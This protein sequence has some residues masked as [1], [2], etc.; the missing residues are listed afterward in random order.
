[1]STDSKIEWCD[2]SFAPWFGCKKVDRECRLCYAE[3]WTVRRFKKAGWGNVPRVRSAA[4]TWRQ[5]LAWQRKAAKEGLR[6]RVFCSHESDVFDNQAR[7]EWRADIWELIRKCPDLDWL[8]LTKRPQNIRKML[9][10]DWGEGW[11]NVW[12]GTTAGHQTAWNRVKALRAI[13]AVLRF[14]S[15]E[16]LL[17]RVD[18][19]LDGISWVICGAETDPQKK[20][21]E[22]F[23]EPDWARDLL[24]QCR[25]AGVA[26][27]MKQMSG[28]APIPDD[29]FVREWP[30]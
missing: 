2:H 25:E 28:H 17:E 15:A 18:A 11:P 8:L 9:P 5:P 20:G 19:N 4:S 22:I 3:D 29:L 13:P 26:F 24:R 7:D 16:P 27:F 6:R 23:M 10:A 14:V 1:M 12:L 21:R 30:R